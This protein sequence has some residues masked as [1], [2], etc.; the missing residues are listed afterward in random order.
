MEIKKVVV[1]LFQTNCYIVS[2][3]N[4]ALL[5]DPGDNFRKIDQQL[6]GYKLLAVLLTHGHC[7]HINAL[8]QVYNKYHCPIH[9][10]AEDEKMLRNVKYN[11]SAMLAKAQTAPVEYLQGNQLI[12]N[13]FTVDILY[14]PGHSKGSVMYL[15]DN[16]LFSGDTLF[17]LSIGRTDLYGGSEHQILQSLQQIKTLDRNIQVYPG[18]GN[19][20]TIGFELDNNRYLQ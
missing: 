12:I 20:T 4:E 14:S 11:V 17:E 16:A 10:C 5:I 18:H 6:N 2:K 13:N 9:I 3:E 1:S 7:D 8:D 19:Q 15:I